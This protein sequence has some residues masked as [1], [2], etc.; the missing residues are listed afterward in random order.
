MDSS[1]SSTQTSVP[2]GHIDSSHSSTQPSVHVPLG[3]MDLTPPTLVS[4][5]QG[6]NRKRHVQTFS[7]GPKE[8]IAIRKGQKTDSLSNQEKIPF[9]KRTKPPKPPPQASK[10]SP[11]TTNCCCRIRCLCFDEELNVC[12][13][14]PASYQ[15][16][17]TY[18][19]SDPFLTWS[20]KCPNYTEVDTAKL[21]HMKH[22]CDLIVQ[23]KFM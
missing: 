15:L 6:P 16:G 7:A 4:S 22:I 13:G 5:A 8:D 11:D 1:H 9:S 23:V 3:R 2:L 19:C 17:D 21:E 10:F 18:F 14:T 20:E 12:A